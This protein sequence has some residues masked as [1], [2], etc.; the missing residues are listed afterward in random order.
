MP[1]LQ[2]TLS[3]VASNRPLSTLSCRPNLRFGQGMLFN[4]VVELKKRLLTSCRLNFTQLLFF[5]YLI[6]LSQK[7]SAL[8]HTR[9]HFI[10]EFKI[11]GFTT[12]FYS[13]VYFF[14]PFYIN[15][16]NKH[17]RPSQCV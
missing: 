4:L 13:Y 5:L 3:H 15:A 16:Q 2:L 12:F 8:S 7:F 1:L 14:F 11:E 17:T 10:F 9:G 6:L